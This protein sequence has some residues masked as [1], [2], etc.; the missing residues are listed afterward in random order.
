MVSVK[1]NG[2]SVHKLPIVY[3]L[4]SKL[5]IFHLTVE[6]RLDGLAEDN[7]SSLEFPQPFGKGE[8]SNS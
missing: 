1:T 3:Y 6:I 2:D 8:P 4:L 5:K 7:G